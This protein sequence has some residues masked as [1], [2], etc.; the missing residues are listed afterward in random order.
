[1]HEIIWAAINVWCAVSFFNDHIFMLFIQ[2]LV[3]PSHK[4]HRQCR[5]KHYIHYQHL[6]FLQLTYY[7]FM[8]VTHQ[9]TFRF[10]CGAKISLWNVPTFQVWENLL[11]TLVEEI[12]L[13]SSLVTTTTSAFLIP[14]QRSGQHRM[15]YRTRKRACMGI[16]Y[17]WT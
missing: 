8:N 11:K 4:M 17:F 3:H 13:I 12:E 1:M 7:T 9:A 16:S 14:S 2:L 10:W 15:E 5:H 6:F